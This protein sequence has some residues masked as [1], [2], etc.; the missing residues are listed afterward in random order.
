MVAPQDVGEAV[1]L[2]GKVEEVAEARAILS[3]GFLCMTVIGQQG[4]GGGQFE[5]N[6]EQ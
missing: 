4:D 6:A 1:V 2:V 5:W 3:R